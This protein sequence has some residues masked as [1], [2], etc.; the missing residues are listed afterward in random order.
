MALEIEILV[1]EHCPHGPVLRKNLIRL[2]AVDF[3]TLGGRP[4]EHD[5]MA[6]SGPPDPRWRGS[7]PRL[8]VG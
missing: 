6:P 7:I 3:L 5:F 1:T 4:W 2:A 8:S